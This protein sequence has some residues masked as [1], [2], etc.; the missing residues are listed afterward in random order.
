[1]LASLGALLVAVAARLHKRGV[2]LVI[3]SEVG[4]VRDVLAAG[5]SAAHL[6]YFAA[7]QEAVESICAGSATGNTSTT[8]NR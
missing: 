3:A 5:G 6:G 4:Q 2:R 8:G 1:M 7:V